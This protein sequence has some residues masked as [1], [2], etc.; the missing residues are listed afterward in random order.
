MP[1]LAFCKVTRSKDRI[2]G[3]F[4]AYFE[5]I[6]RVCAKNGFMPAMAGWVGVSKDTPENLVTGNANLTQ[7][8]ALYL[9]FI[10]WL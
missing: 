1:E 7:P 3:F 4:I 6:F 2:R 10:G 8:A 9:A 5:V